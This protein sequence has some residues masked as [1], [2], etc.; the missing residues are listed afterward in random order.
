MRKLRAHETQ[1]INA[2]EARVALF[3][4][5]EFPL[6]LAGIQILS[7]QKLTEGWAG[8]THLI[9]FKAEPLRGVSLLEI[10]LRLGL[11]IVDR[12]MGGPGRVEST[13]R[14]ISEIEKALLDQ[15]VQIILEEWCN[16]WAAVKPL[17]TT[18][19]GCESSGRFLQTA[20]PQTNMLTVAIEA[21][22]GEAT[23]QIKLAFPYAA[24]EP[25][26]RQLCVGSEPVTETPAPAPSAPVKWNR[27]LD[28]VALPV[29][30]EW[31]GLELSARDV[32]HLKVGDVLQITPQLA[33]QVSLRLGEIAKFNGRLG[34]VGGH[35]AVELTQAI[36]P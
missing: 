22:L 10:P 3:L 2:M 1:F 28:N 12:L 30:A 31:Q 16:N 27:S 13:T 32:L 7:Y 4:R 33:E 26:L 25:C 17:K 19:L 9:L 29:A 34:T 24:M 35:W 5:S 21:R 14:E 23:G 36:K 18:P 8:P 11:T 20:P 6:K 15:I